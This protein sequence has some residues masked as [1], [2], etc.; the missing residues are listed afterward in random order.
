VANLLHEFEMNLNDSDSLHSYTI[1]TKHMCTSNI[2][3]AVWACQCQCSKHTALGA[4][5]ARLAVLVSAQGFADALGLLRCSEDLSLKASLA[6]TVITN[7]HCV[8]HPHARQ[9]GR[10]PSLAQIQKNKAII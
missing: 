2:D 3:A 1:S 7:H 5:A 6:I 4:Q 8:L 9:G 10:S